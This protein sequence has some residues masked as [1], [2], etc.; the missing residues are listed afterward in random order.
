V[1]WSRDSPVSCYINCPNL[2]ARGDGTGGKVC[3]DVSRQCQGML[4]VNFCSLS[5]ARSSLMRTCEEFVICSIFES[6]CRAHSKLRHTAPGILSMANAGKDTNGSQ[7][8][9][10]TSNQT[11]RN[12]RNLNSILFSSLPLSSPAGWTDDTSFLERFLRAWISF[13]KLVSIDAHQAFRAF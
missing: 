5:M 11:L 2:S 13:V 6:L 12:T 1:R 8:V 3:S 10:Q 9:S 4:T 7:F